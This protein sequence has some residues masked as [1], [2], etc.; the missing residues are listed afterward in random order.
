MK[1]SLL[2][3]VTILVCLV[4]LVPQTAQAE[5]TI[6]IFPERYR[7][8]ALALE[9]HYEGQ[10]FMDTQLISIE[11]I[12][13]LYGDSTTSYLAEGNNFASGVY[14]TDITQMEG[15]DDLPP[16]NGNFEAAISNDM[17]TLYQFWPHNIASFTYGESDPFGRDIDFYQA[18]L[19]RVND[20]RDIFGYIRDLLDENNGPHFFPEAMNMVILGSSNDV[21][22]SY[23]L[24]DDDFVSGRGGLVEWIPTDFFYAVDDF[25]DFITEFRI[26]RIPVHAADA[27][28][29]DSAAGGLTFTGRYGLISI[30]AGGLTA[31]V[32]T[33]H[34]DGDDT[35]A[36]YQGAFANGNALPGF[37]G[38]NDNLAG[39]TV[40]YRGV[41]DEYTDPQNGLMQDARIDD[42]VG[43][44]SAYYE[45]I[46]NTDTS[47][48]VKGATGGVFGRFYGAGGTYEHADFI[49]FGSDYANGFDDLGAATNTT[50]IDVPNDFSQAAGTDMP[51]DAMEGYSIRFMSDTP[52]NGCVTTGLV[53]IV[54]NDN[55]TAIF[56]PWGNGNNEPNTIQ[57]R[58]VGMVGITRSV[59]QGQTASVITWTNTGP[60]PDVEYDITNE[61]GG[62]APAAGWVYRESN[63][64]V[65][66]G[67]WPVVAYNGTGMLTVA[68][69]AAGDAPS[70]GGLAELWAPANA[71]GA[72][73]A[74]GGYAIAN[75]AIWEL[76]TP[77]PVRSQDSGDDLQ[78][79]DTTDDARM[80]I[81]KNI[82][83]W[84]NW[85][86]GTRDNPDDDTDNW[87]RRC[88]L[89][90]GG[91][92]ANWAYFGELLAL[93]VLNS[94]DTTDG[95]TLLNGMAVHKYFETDRDLP[96][97]LVPAT[98]QAD[99]GGIIST[100][101][102]ALDMSQIFGWTAPVGNVGFGMAYLV[103]AP[104]NDSG[105]I[106]MADPNDN[107]YLLRDINDDPG[108]HLNASDVL[109]LRSVV[110]GA[111]GDA[112]PTL[113]IVVSNVDTLGMWDMET[114]VQ[115]S[116]FVAGLTP[117][118]SSFGQALLSNSTGTADDYL[119]S[120]GAI[121]FLSSSRPNYHL[122][123][124]QVA[125]GVI[126]LTDTN[127]MDEMLFRVFQEYH[128]GLTTLGSLLVKV[129][130]DYVT[131]NDMT[132]S[133]HQR[134][135]LTLCL[136]GNP[137]LFI[138][139]AKNDY[140]DQPM[141]FFGAINL[142]R[143]N[144][145]SMPVVDIPDG[146]IGATATINK[147]V[148]F[149]IT[150]ANDALIDI[151]IYDL[152]N[153]EAEN[154]DAVNSFGAP[155]TS[156]L[157]PS[158]QSPD[159]TLGLDDQDLGRSTPFATPL[160]PT[161]GPSVYMVR[162]SVRQTNPQGATY[163]KERRLYLDA[164]N[165]FTPAHDIL[166]VDDDEEDMYRM[167]F[168]VFM[169]RPWDEK[170]SMDINMVRSMINQFE[171]NPYFE[172]MIANYY[173]TGEN[174]TFTGGSATVTGVGTT[175]ASAV[176]PTV[177]PGYWIKAFRPDSGSALNPIWYRIQSVD[178]DTQLTLTAN[179]AATGESG[180]G[181]AYTIQ[182][183][184]T[185]GFANVTDGSPTATG[186]GNYWDDTAAAGDGVD[187]DIGDWIQFNFSPPGVGLFDND[188]L[189]AD[190]DWGSWYRI[191]AI[192]N[193]LNTVTLDR[194]Y[195][196]PL[197][198][199]G[200]DAVFHNPLTALPL[201]VGN[202]CANG[203]MRYR[204][205]SSVDNGTYGD[206]RRADVWHQDND[207]GTNT[208]PTGGGYATRG[209]HGGQGRHGE[210]YENVLVNYNATT[211]SDIDRS[212][213]WAAG[214]AGGGY[215]RDTIMAGDAEDGSG[216]SFTEQDEVEDF[217]QEGGRMFLSGENIGTDFAD[218]TDGDP[219]WY[220]QY[221]HAEF[222]QNSVEI[223]EVDGV[224]GDNLSNDIRDL[225]IME[226]EGS[227]SSE[228]MDEIDAAATAT[229]MM[230]YSPAVGEEGQLLS[231]G[232]SGIRVWD[233][234]TNN[235]A[236]VYMAFNLDSVDNAADIFS[237]R[238]FVFK[239]V[240]DWMRNPTP[241]GSN[242]LKATPDSASV[243]T[244]GSQTFTA[245]GGI[246]PYTW[247]LIDN[248]SGSTTTGPSNG[249]TFAY[250]A[251]TVGPVTDTLELQD[252]ATPTPSTV[253]IPI[254]VGKTGLL[255]IT[256]S[257][258]TVNALGSQGF[259]ASG[260]TG[261][262]TWTLTQNQSGS[263]T[264]SGNGSTFA[265]T[266]GAS[267]GTDILELSDGVNN[268]TATITITGG[269]AGLSISPSS[270]TVLPNGTQGFT[271]SGGT[272]TYTWTLTQNQS[273]S[274]TTSGNG[275][276]FSYTAGATTG[277]DIL[278]LGDGSTTD[279]ATI[280]VSTSGGGGGG[281][282]S[283][284]IFGCFVA[285]ASFGHAMEEDLVVLRAFRD[286]NLLVNRI[287]EDYVSTYYRSSPPLADLISQNE[288]LRAVGRDCLKV[289][290][291]TEPDDR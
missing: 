80:M 28:I 148:T 92:H 222:V 134:T 37:A 180:E 130:E 226:G 126:S 10:L 242:E 221:L 152:R 276:T 122:Y 7:S 255:A 107:N 285:T 78:I 258:A 66:L 209:N 146:T 217:L 143:R 33:Y 245:S 179:W 193:V 149:E 76:Y 275:S 85:S 104:G 3:F 249:T 17:E 216:A 164:V 252:S 139:Q 243:D 174:V 23:Y 290:T 18:S 123:A 44:A 273:G 127:F 236:L 46:A 235:Y 54:A 229:P 15:F 6:I 11:S 269:S 291:Q 246:A 286:S 208:S 75:G 234:A 257:S 165:V 67:I 103:G 111:A 22:P 253:Y 168:T 58:F 194:N 206:L 79:Y 160:D 156:G 170:G 137:L 63:Q 49:V 59:D 142:D 57:Y 183:S 14:P 74:A 248:Q 114:F 73:N 171:I 96:E 277:T 65:T 1:R 86:N 262:Y 4:P 112:F 261:T 188:A 136:L 39:A 35:A 225:T 233:T 50:F 238:N 176:Q 140:T 141:P 87:F 207:N 82:Q 244:S 178:S 210:I 84:T 175:W 89:A 250:T 260:G 68:H 64:G 211:Q 83:W 47:L 97:A 128:R 270:A 187:F 71:A 166:I 158:A 117:F 138:P 263:G 272:G 145:W 212:V 120:G 41:A 287:G 13:E 53:R 20:V 182:S 125:N 56:Q 32:P 119:T 223:F 251:G 213:I 30:I 31:V 219:A 24:L 173:E 19:N 247:T 70:G 52:D 153:G 161:N 195:G 259:T 60:D 132:D 205:V 95:K 228:M 289:L 282:S 162:A 99:G 8:A 55:D 77:G 227:N 271:A 36:T 184:Y 108:A 98:Q 198:A 113:P 278:Q 268:T 118:R 254:D 181:L 218:P 215:L 155:Y 167:G 192:D 38:G 224:A 256:P 150:Q 135:L 280:T 191:I 27:P 90:A 109:K 2:L 9:L 274:G 264:T 72:Y 25:T 169:D 100:D 190:M 69:D 196:D 230:F 241:T 200:V 94:V 239:R 204:I 151:K 61:T 157:T 48:L 124:P 163:A 159:Y 197:D 91:M 129:Q 267:N 147:N 5:G 116:G 266:A 237:G 220:E 42:D 284:S 102:E 185:R 154:T 34:A 110:T 29:L 172:A 88:A 16:V 105:D 43:I 26:G 121:A 40:I 279:N 12:Y 131:A 189:R 288:I 21:P 265:Y 144:S 81:E 283:G 177:R 240:L 281:G 231:T 101:F 93:D 62:N 214:I 202:A 45:V 199:I 201:P 106:F 51:N 115:N 203:S 232:A 186:V 133:R